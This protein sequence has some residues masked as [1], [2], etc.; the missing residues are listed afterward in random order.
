MPAGWVGQKSRGCLQRSPVLGGLDE[1]ADVV[2][3]CGIDT[4]AV[5]PCRELDGPALRRPGW[6]LEEL[7]VLVAGLMGI[8]LAVEFSS[9]GLASFRQGR[10]GRD[11]GTCRM[12]DFRSMVTGTDRMVEAPEAGSHGNGVLFTKGALSVTRVGRALRRYSLDE[13][14]QLFN[15]FKGEMS[16]VGPCPP[17][18]REAEEPGPT[19]TG[20]S[21]S[22]RG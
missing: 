1:V 8:A 13:L 14:P 20:G 3:A 15:V 5:L 21:S 2:R 22:S 18:Q 19:C 6:A 16:L 17:L 4:V 9:C 11:G 10:V 12:P 7:P